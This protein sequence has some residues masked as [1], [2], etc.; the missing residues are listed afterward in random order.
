MLR[1]VPNAPSVADDDRCLFRAGDSCV[2]QVPVMHERLGF[3]N[4][5][6]PAL[7]FGA[8]ALVKCQRVSERDVLHIVAFDLRLT[9]VEE[10]GVNTGIRIVRLDCSD[11]PV[12]YVEVVI[13][14]KLDDLVVKIKPGSASGG[15]VFNINAVAFLLDQPLEN[16]V[17]IVDAEEALL[18]RGKELNA[19]DDVVSELL[20]ED[21]LV[22]EHDEIQDVRLLGVFIDE[23]PAF[24][25]LVRFR[26]SGNAPVENGDAVFLQ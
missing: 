5:H 14:A 20:V 6:N 26:V 19:V 10:D 9:L 4:D 2:E 23:I 18:H 16:D 15:N 8:L 7:V 21:F 13:V 25:S 17:Q 1:A 11:G 3:V 12:H 24:P 22:H